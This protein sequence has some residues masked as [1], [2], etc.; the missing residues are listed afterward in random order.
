MPGK[1]LTTS[2]DENTALFVEENSRIEGW[3]SS[4]TLAAALALYVR[5][6][7]EARRSFRVVEAYGNRED[8]IRTVGAVTR[9]LLNGEYEVARRKLASRLDIATAIDDEDALLAVADRMVK[10][11]GP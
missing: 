4:Q 9:A 10:D 3:S 11:F 6:P 2:V 7:P 1:T 8:Q 5:L